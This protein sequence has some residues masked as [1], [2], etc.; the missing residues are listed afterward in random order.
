MP[1]TSTKQNVLGLIKLVEAGRMLDAM[2]TYYAPD[3]AM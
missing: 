2:T 3:I 1:A